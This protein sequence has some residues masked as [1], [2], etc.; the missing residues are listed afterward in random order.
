MQTTTECISVYID[1]KNRVIITE[2]L[3]TN[4]I[5]TQKRFKGHEYLKH[6]RYR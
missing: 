1:N 6:G 2:T 4:G 3:E 5:R